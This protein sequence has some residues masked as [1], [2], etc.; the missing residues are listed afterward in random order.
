VKKFYLNYK[1]VPSNP[2]IEFA[3]KILE[4]AK[5]AT[6]VESKGGGS[7]IDTG[8][9]IAY[10]LKIPHTA[11]PTTAGTGSEATKYAV[12][13]KDGKKFS[14]EDDK[15]IPDKYILNPSL[16]ISL[17][18]EQTIASGLDAL[19]QSI[20]SFWS[21][22]STSES[23]DY[24]KKAV[25]LITANL[26]SSVRNPK[27]EYSRMGMLEAAN[28]SGKAINITRTSICHALS[29]P[30]TAKREIP[31]GIACAMFLPFFMRYF[32][33]PDKTI[34]KISHL[35]SELGVKRERLT[36]EDIS[37]ALESER[38]KNT[39]KPIKRELLSKLI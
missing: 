31:H 35:L 10:K 15:L 39:P 3:D 14:L 24:S 30:L 20:E 23:R 19:S 17:P 6:E 2:T 5:G 27:N 37:E 22:L 32:N 12:F 29:Y 1:E 25:H 38:S 26:P 21:P 33:M 4:K 11:I 34:S 36:D 16:V 13:V 18:V 8:K 28:Y 9:Y 7:T